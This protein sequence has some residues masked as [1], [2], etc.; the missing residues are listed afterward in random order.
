MMIPRA[1]DVCQPQTSVCGDFV[2]PGTPQA[3][4]THVGQFPESGTCP[5]TRCPQVL[6]PSLRDTSQPPTSARRSLA[7]RLSRTSRYPFVVIPRARNVC[8]PPPPRHLLMGRTPEMGTSPSPGCPRRVMLE[9]GKARG[10]VWVPDAQWP[11]SSR[12]PSLANPPRGL[13][14]LSELA[15]PGDP[16]F[17]GSQHFSKKREFPE[18]ISPTKRVSRRLLVYVC[19]SPR[20]W[21]ALPRS[22][23]LPFGS[24]GSR[25]TSRGRGSGPRP[26]EMPAEPCF[27]P[28]AQDHRVRQRLPADHPGEGSQHRRL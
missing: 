5:S 15:Q 13:C 25:R 6:I 18:L 19:G 2:E 21:E 12:A 26:A 7:P 20:A 14:Q 8:E 28:R 11:G 24:A 23:V 27:S 4:D 16:S 9:P 22:K 17:G 1:G 10:A 3:P